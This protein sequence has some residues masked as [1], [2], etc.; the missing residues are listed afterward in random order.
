VTH[1]QASLK[2]SSVLLH[3]Y[4]LRL[5]RC[6]VVLTNQHNVIPC[7]SGWYVHLWVALGQRSM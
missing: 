7:V 6:A 1:E 4:P 2:V 5:L 3:I